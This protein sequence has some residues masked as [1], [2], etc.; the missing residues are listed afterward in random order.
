MVQAMLAMPGGSSLLSEES[1]EATKGPPQAMRAEFTLQRLQKPSLSKFKTSA[2]TATLSD[3][4]RKVEEQYKAELGLMDDIQEFLRARARLSVEYSSGLQK[5]TQQF[6]SK[7]KWSPTNYVEGHDKILSTE[8]FRI[9]LNSTQ[10]EAKAHQ[11]AADLIVNSTGQSFENAKDDKRILFKMA[12]AAVSGLQE[13]LLKLDTSVAQCKK[14]YDSTM[15]E[16]SQIK[17]KAKKKSDMELK[18]AEV[19]AQT[20]RSL[21]LLELAAANGFYLKYR[22]EQLPEIMDSVRKVDLQFLQKLHGNIAVYIDNIAH[23]VAEESARVAKLSNMMDAEFEWRSFVHESR[24]EF[25][26]RQLFEMEPYSAEENRDLIVDHETR[27]IL[28]NVRKMFDLSVKSLKDEIVEKEEKMDSLQNLFAHYTKA[29]DLFETRQIQTMREKMEILHADIEATATKKLLLDLK[30]ERIT[31]TGIDQIPTPPPSP[32]V[33]GTVLDIDV[34]QAREED[35]RERMKAMGDSLSI[36]SEHSPQMQKKIVLSRQPSEATEYGASGIPAGLVLGRGAPKVSEFRKESKPAVPDAPPPPLPSL[37][38]NAIYA[39]AKAIDASRALPPLQKHTVMTKPVPVHSVPVPQL[40]TLLPTQLPPQLPQIPQLPP[41]LPA[42]PPPAA[43]RPSVD[44]IL[45]APELPPPPEYPETESVDDVPVHFVAL[46]DYA[47]QQ[48]DDLPLKQDEIVLVLVERSDGWCQ[49]INAAGEVGFF[50]LSYVR[51]IREHEDPRMAIPKVVR[52]QNTPQ[53]GFAFSGQNPARVQ[54][55]RAGSVASSAGL[56][57]G[58]IVIEV[59]SQPVADCDGDAILD[60]IHELPL[61]EELRLCV[62]S[63]HTFSSAKPELIRQTSTA[64]LV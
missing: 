29:G 4:L 61:G 57:S 49:G 38:H 10:E 26:A 3:Q 52:L 14:E 16:L 6:Y 31:Q 63:T 39:A 51:E 7:R 60:M 23:V 62:L 13:E 18:R 54:A 2:R 30:I 21:Y 36:D 1:K 20:S 44:I 27:P 64:S 56:R 9:L 34:A 50:P 32:T 41:Q 25:G 22:N 33:E 24:Q 46:Y 12:F 45:M 47:G 15:K 5:L 59:N 43:A 28:L 11:H 42:K 35:R 58:D 19:K 55:V 40:P 8:L 17:K 53:L 48:S 37:E